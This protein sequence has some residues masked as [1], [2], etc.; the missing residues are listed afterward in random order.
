MRGVVGLDVALHSAIERCASNPVLEQ[1]NSSPAPLLARSR[2]ET[3]PS[4]PDARTPRGD[5]GS[6]CELA[7]RCG[8]ERAMME[9]LQAVGLYLISERPR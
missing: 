7:V 9:H 2:E 8:A 1:I 6:D 4:R 5:S 3:L